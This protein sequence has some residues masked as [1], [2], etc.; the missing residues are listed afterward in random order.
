MKS[1]LENEIIKYGFIETSC[2]KNNITIYEREFKESTVILT[3][4]H[5]LYTLSL[6][7]KNDPSDDLM[8][9]SRYECY[10]PQDLDYLIMRSRIGVKFS[11]A[12]H[13]G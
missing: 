3:V 9:A 10:T 7:F 5:P 12:Y 8:I 2:D 11:N 4:L 1:P 13:I 6:Y